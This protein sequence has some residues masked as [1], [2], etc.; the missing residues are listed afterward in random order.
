MGTEKDIANMTPKQLEEYKKLVE[1]KRA[2]KR[3]LL[4]KGK[5]RGYLSYKEIADALAAYETT[6][7]EMEKL[8]DRYESE[9]IE[10]VEDMEKEL[11]EIEVS[12]EELEDLSVPEGINI[13]DHVK[14]YLKEI[15]KVDLLSAEEETRLAKLMSEGDEDAKKK[16][17]NVFL[18]GY[19]Y[20]DRASFVRD[21]GEDAAFILNCCLK[22]INNSFDNVKLKAYEGVVTNVVWYGLKEQ[23][24]RILRRTDKCK[25]KI[26]I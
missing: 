20:K 6:P 11:E 23:T 4:E 7:E 3:G 8:Y 25:Q 2:I 19:E 9:K 18:T 13:D 26:R 5:K 1:A 22:E 12:K 24:D 16:E 17:F 15:G 10:L 14:M 21:K